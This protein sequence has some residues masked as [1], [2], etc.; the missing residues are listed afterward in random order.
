MISDVQLRSFL[1]HGNLDSL[2]R[3]PL[4]CSKVFSE[5]RSCSTV[6]DDVI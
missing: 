4:V 2:C 3:P 6:S 5:H 1:F